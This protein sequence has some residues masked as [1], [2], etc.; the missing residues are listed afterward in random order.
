MANRKT[1]STAKPAAKQPD[2]SVIIIN[3]NE[4]DV[5]VTLELLAKQKLSQAYETIV[6]DASKGALDDIYDKYPSLVRI[7]FTS[8][9]GKK[10]TIPE[11]RNVGVR[12]AKGNI[13][14]FIDAS[15]EPGPTWLKTLTAPIL[16]S[17]E[18]I[19]AGGTLSSG[20]KTFHDVIYNS[21]AQQTYVDQAPT[22]NL[23]IAKSI[24]A[25]IGYFDENL[26]YGHGLYLAGAKSRP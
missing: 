20:G 10:V 3:K 4:R 26:R 21:Q 17:K 9:T 11:Q 15:C 5:D 23:A 6:V 1:K 24:F 7:D 12:A 8:K 18:T 25:E 14:V 13:I 16:E 19:T 22:I 2:I